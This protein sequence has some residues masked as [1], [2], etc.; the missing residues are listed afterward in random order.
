MQHAGHWFERI[1]CERVGKASN[2]GRKP[3]RKAPA[4]R[5]LGADI[6]V[7]VAEGPA[8]NIKPHGI[9]SIDQSG[10]LLHLL[11]HTRV[12]HQLADGVHQSHGE[13]DFSILL[14]HLRQGS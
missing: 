14:A 7:G 3:G 5:Q 1:K 12:H 9:K 8:L 13:C 6:G 10:H 2:R 11:G 4:L